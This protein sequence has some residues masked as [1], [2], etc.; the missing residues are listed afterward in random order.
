MA[1]LRPIS[2]KKLIKVLSRM[3]FQTVRQK[4]SHM[5]LEHLEGRR[6]TVPIHPNEEIDRSLIRMIIKE[7]KITKE[8]F[9]KQLE[10]IWTNCSIQVFG[11]P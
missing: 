11:F 4:G 7:I 9:I 5:R 1:E 8:E 2:A 3:G 10:E 6:V